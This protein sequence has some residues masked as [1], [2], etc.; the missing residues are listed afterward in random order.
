[1]VRRLVALAVLA[2]AI[3]AGDA[4]RCLDAE[5]TPTANL[6]IVAWLETASGTYVDT[7]FITQQTGTFGLGNRPGRYDFNSGPAW[8][9][10]RRIN[11]FPVW[12]HRNG[13]AFPAV[14]YQND[15]N[16]DPTYCATLPVGGA[17]YTSCGENDLSH[18][19]S[20]S[21]IENHYCQPLL[22][23]NPAFDAMTCPSASFTDKG[24]FS[25]DPSMTTGYPPRIDLVPQI[26]ANLPDSPSTA[27]FKALDPFDAVSQPTPIGGTLAH[28]PW[29]VPDDLPDGDYVLYVETALESDFNDTYNASTYPPPSDIAWGAYGV[30]TRGQPSIVYAVPITVSAG[31]TTSSTLTFA[32]YGDP[33]GA[34]GVLRPP[35][36]T[37]ST[38][39]PAS[40]ASR[41]QLVSDGTT[42]Y[43]LRVTVAP[44]DPSKLPSSPTELAAT[45]VTASSATVAFAAP[46][47][48]G[49]AVTG[50]DIRVLADQPMTDDNFAGATPITTKVTP[51]AP[52]AMQSVDVAGLLPITDYWIGIRAFNSCNDEGPLA[53]VHVTTTDRES[54]T[55]DACFVA[56]AAYGSIMANDVELLR[57]FRDTWL[58][59]NV[60]GELGVEAYYTFGP[61]LAGIVGESD[62]LRATARD[63]LA[64][65]VRAIRALGR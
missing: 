56:T 29:G 23:T 51:V 25:T 33:T 35:D 37:I 49:A 4:K 9:Y 22:P 30:P 54:G 38:D 32:G 34:D 41:L 11:T 63:L 42:M 58:Q 46:G 3:A 8:P 14:I 62:L 10:G 13:Q 12:A 31:T 59:T 5:L 48:A 2:P 40:G 27:M 28:A 36:A 44:D 18:P 52:G 24:R 45:S 64:P 20:Q 1:M 65:I 6:Q 43:R 16:E 17:S 55:V 15:P 7:V 50:Y 21:S 61:A 47:I 26:G 39:T 19:S 57:H 53:I 60:V